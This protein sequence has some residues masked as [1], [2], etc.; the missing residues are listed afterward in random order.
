MLLAHVCQLWRGGRRGCVWEGLIRRVVCGSGVTPPPSLQL[1]L[2]LQPPPRPHVT[3]ARMHVRA[4]P[5]TRTTHI[6]HSHMRTP[7]LAPCSTLRAA[8]I[9]SCRAEVRRAERMLRTRNASPLTYVTSLCQV[10][11]DATWPMRILGIPLR[12]LI[13]DSSFITYSSCGEGGKG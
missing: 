13:S 12:Q 4:N 11:G 9:E 5:R 7:T 6:Q 8:L 1:Q 10:G 3:Y 2:R